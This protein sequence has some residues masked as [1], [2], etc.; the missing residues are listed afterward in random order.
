MA[1][2]T[3]EEIAKLDDDELEQFGQKNKAKKTK[4]RKLQGWLRWLQ[5]VL[6]V[7]MA[8]YHFYTAVNTINPHTQRA[9]HLLFVLVF[10]FLLYPAR[11]GSP[12]A[13]PSVCDV[14][15]IVLSL[16]AVGFLLYR[17]EELAMMAGR[18][19]RAD[20]IWGVVSL[21]LV[22]EATRRVVGYTLPVFAVIMLLYGYF[23]EFVPGMLGHSGFSVNRIVSHLTLTTGGIYGQILGVS[24]MYIFLFILFGAFLGASGLTA[25]FNDIAMA[26]SGSTRG[27]PAKVSV[28]ASGLMGSISGS[29]TANVV[30]TG[31]FTIPLMKKI[32]YKDYFAGAVEAASS[33]GGQVMPP[34]MGS[35]AFII[36]D[37]LGVPYS[38]VLL[39]ALIPAILYYFSLW[40]MIDLRARKEGIKGLEQDQIPDLM[41]V[42]RE[43]GHL[44]LPLAVIIYMLVAGYNATWA[45]ISGIIISVVASF[46]RRSTW[47]KPSDLLKALES[48]VL[49]ALSVAIACAII[50][51]IIGIFSLTGIILAIGSAIL[52]FSGGK[53][54][55]TLVLTMFVS[56]ILGMGLPTTACYVLTSTV[57]APALIGL[58]VLP[59]Q[60]HM[61]VFYFGIL[62]TIT[63]PVAAGSYAAAGLSGANPN[64]TGWMG[65]RLACAGFIVPYM[66]IYSPELLLP[67]GINVLVALRVAVTSLIGIVCLG[68]AMEGYFKRR[69]NIVERCIA[70]ASAFALIDSGMLTDAAG[71]AGFAAVIASQTLTARQEKAVQKE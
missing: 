6:V 55:L 59:M 30:T 68:L 41:K 8:A 23:G 49:S 52:S 4:R 10:V 35:A 51:I 42:L 3:A 45:A 7:L 5:L 15:L 50:G 2:I 43:R 65:V 28:L 13:R 54:W 39:A 40:I 27:G 33:A 32:G 71:V 44:M 29:T 9:I 19:K 1:N 53:L 11:K 37:S 21:L 20:I 60:A 64:K 31:A 69:L 61:F 34:V 57:A 18:Y 24:S 22:I 63:P 17:F 48:G 12:A 70:L 38:K 66:F 58:N 46:L 62:S 36:A 25:V 26:L 56:L 67:E 14:I 16:C 47:I